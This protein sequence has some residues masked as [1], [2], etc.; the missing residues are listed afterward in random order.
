MKFVVQAASAVMV[1]VAS[2]CSAPGQGTSNPINGSAP[3]ARWSLLLEEVVTIPNSSGSA[4]RLEY[5]VGNAATGLAYVVD[6]RGPV[7]TFDPQATNPTASLLVDL[8]SAVGS[9]RFNNEAGVRGLAFHPD[10][11]NLEAPGYR[12]MYV[13]LSRTTGSTPVG[14]PTQFVDPTSTTD[15]QTVVS[16]FT[17][18]GDGSVDVASYRELMRIEQPFPNHNSGHLGFNPTAMPGDSDY[19]NLYVSVG[20]GGGGSGPFDLS[21]DIDVT[22]APYPHGKILRIDPLGSPYSI[23]ADNPFA[24]Q[25]DRVQ[26]TWAYGLRN[27]HKFEWDAVTGEMYVS[28]IGQGVVEEISVGRAGANYGWNEREGTYVFVNGGTVSPLPAGHAT[29]SFDYP[30]AQYDHSGTNGISGSSAIV[31]GPVYRGTDVPELTGLYF[32]A[33]FASNP[34]PIFAVDV[35]DL[36]VRD[37]FSNVSS[38]D[39]GRLA[40][41]EEIEIRSGGVDFDFRQI[42][43]QSLGNATQSRTDLRWGTDA[44]GEL[45]LLNKHDGIVRRVAGVVGLTAGDANRDGTVDGTDVARWEASYGLA[46]DWSDGNFDAGPVVDGDDFILWQRNAGGA[47]LRAVPEPGALPAILVAAGLATISSTRPRKGR[48]IP[49]KAAD[50]ADAVLAEIKKTEAEIDEKTLVAELKKNVDQK[51]KDFAVYDKMIKGLKT[52]L[53]T[54]VVALARDAKSVRNVDE[55]KESWSENIRGVGTTLPQLAGDLGLEAEHKRWRTYASQG[56]FPKTDE[57]VSSKYAALLPDLKSIAAAVR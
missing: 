28:D 39:G 31:G 46:G 8:N 1:F 14:N 35:D 3:I 12:K 42:L 44:D 16:E 32:F 25:T 21:Q 55:F 29:D 7:Y 34:G 43:R 11:D 10:F 51:L 36:I 30:V 56:F 47:P 37:D 54:Y 6:Q 22:P 38:L 48:T 45:Y 19:G 2:T 52:K 17:L 53:K 13:A 40:P 57:E 33:D 27:P 4:P 24:G 23:P 50:H 18:E 9:L 5:L 15:H 26:E 49:K 20:D 41:F